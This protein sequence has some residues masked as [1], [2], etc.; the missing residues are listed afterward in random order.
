MEKN[1]LENLSDIDTML[2]EEFGQVANDQDNTETNETEVN[3]EDENTTN[4]DDETTENTNET[5]ESAEGADTNNETETAETTEDTTENNVNEISNQASNDKSHHAFADLRA[6][7]TNLRKEKEALEADSSFL[8]DLAASYGYTDTKEFAKAYK[9]AK[10]KKEAQAKGYDVELYRQTI[11]Q[12]ERIE[13]LE[14]QREDDIRNRQLNLFKSAM[15]KAVAD[16]NVSEDEIFDRLEKSGLNAE[17][18]LSL[19]NP[20]LILNGLLVDKIRNNAEQKQIN[21]LSKLQNFTEDK[22]ENGGSTQ[23]VSIDSLLKDDL[24]KY[25]ADNFFE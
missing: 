24:A 13:A 25:K 8:K 21:T 2:D 1:V 7:N 12:K 22:N 19:P 5:E 6:Q 11:E 18:L 3:T 16:Y 4:V 9:E 10:I 17:Q 14:R 23:T 20:S 15:D